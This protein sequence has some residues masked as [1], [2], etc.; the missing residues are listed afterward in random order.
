MSVPTLDEVLA[1]PPGVRG[2]RVL[3]RAD[4]N[5]P[6]E[7]G[8]VSDDTRL[9]AAL[10]TL[11][12]LLSAGARVVLCSHLGRPKGRV[13]PELSLEPVSAALAALLQRNVAFCPESSGPTAESAVASLADGEL[14]LL[15]NLRFD[16]G[17]EANDPAFADALAALADVYIND[18]FGTAHRAHAST[19]GVAVRVARRG[20]GDCLRGELAHLEAVRSP[21]RPL[22][23]LLG[24]AKVSDKLAVLEALAP[25]ADVLAVG[26]AMAYTFLRAQ[27][28]PTGDSL[29]ETDRIEDAARVL[30]AAER[31]GRT[32]LLPTDHVVVE[33]FEADAPSRVVSEIPEGMIAVDIGP[34]TAERYSAEARAAATLFWNGPMGVFE[35]PAFAKGTFAV[36][37]AVAEAPGH[38]VVGGGDSLAAVNRAGVAE[39]VDHLSTGGGASLEFVQG[40]TLPGVAALEEDACVDR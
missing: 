34:E 30:E 33:R 10:P 23:C 31:S 24:G 4:L 39:A 6:L 18:A 38:T 36:A 13:V 2:A 26:G 20:A 29:I 21:T 19:A 5:V 1:A 16:P 27:G 37:K 25:H 11:R 32:L 14:L 9:K 35:M 12:K 15:E 8:R 7:A 28:L 22:L 17:E 3:V 40:L